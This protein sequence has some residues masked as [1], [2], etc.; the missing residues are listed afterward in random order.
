MSIVLVGC[1]S[2]TIEESTLEMKKGTTAEINFT[3]KGKGD[4]T[5]TSSNE[6][7]CTVDAGKVTAVGIGEATVK[8][9]IK[10]KEASI[11]VV[12]SEQM[13]TSIVLKAE[14]DLDYYIAG[15]TYQFSASIL[16]K[17]ADQSATYTSSNNDVATVDAN[18]LVTALSAGQTTITTT[19]VKDSSKIDSYTINV[20][21]PDPEEVVVSGEK[22]VELEESIQLSAKVNP[23]YAVQAV[24]WSS[25]DESIA[26]VTVDGLVTGLKVGEVNI[27]AKALTKDT[28]LCNYLVKVITPHVQSV[29]I[30]GDENGVF[31]DSSTQL[32][33]TITPALAP[34]EVVWSTSDDTIASITEDGLVT[35][36]KAGQVFITATAASDSTKS[37]S[38][39]FEVKAAPERPNN[40][41]ILIDPYFEGLKF[42][43]TTYL[44]YDFVESYNLF[45]SLENVDAE[46]KE[47]TVIYFKEGDI[48]GTLNISH[49]NV[50]IYGPNKDNN[51]LDTSTPRENEAYLLGSIKFSGNLEG[52]EINGI[53]LGATASIVKD[54]TGTFKNFKFVNNYSS[55]DTKLTSLIIIDLATNKDL[56]NENILLMNNE[57][58]GVSN[59]NDNTIFFRGSNIKNLLVNNNKFFMCASA[60]EADKI[61]DLGGDFNGTDLSS[62]GY[63]ING[64][65]EFI[66]N[67]LT[68]SQTH[69]IEIR[70]YAKE[71][72]TINILNNYF[73]GKTWQ[74]VSSSKV[75]ISGYMGASVEIHVDYNLFTN[76]F[77][78]V[79]L[80]TNNVTSSSVWSATV[81]Y[82]NFDFYDFQ[83]GYVANRKYDGNNT[84]ISG[85]NE[86]ILIDAR[87]NFYKDTQ[88]LNAIDAEFAKRLV[89]V[90]EVSKTTAYAD[91]N[92][93]PRYTGSY[94][95]S[96]E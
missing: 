51:P 49:N 19:A 87:Y 42:D 57:I 91:E 88:S 48:D 95:T 20:K 58:N 46:I 64:K 32:S 34:Q 59:S 36:L 22:E 25:A 27:V 13:P 30:S 45:R 56:V 78:G 41:V 33:A 26:T 96:F 28:V 76:G 31:I 11:L 94:S 29:S 52:I 43:A 54:P 82:N 17:N 37:F 50:K 75:S 72:T 86:S 44:G 83:A 40:N 12:V 71:A 67:T 23:K 84:A 80:A 4:V 5:W 61:F 21:L 89:G 16:P 39:L 85:Y 14:E 7:V 55:A 63:G 68:S 10:D 8:A 47:D 15:N 1:T 93:I 62:S 2:I 73:N 77:R 53:A 79:I 60:D 70:G 35:G 3:V 38:V 18:G 9:T 74:Y 65:I 92:E 81:N 6:L 69:D 24:T 66:N 90:T